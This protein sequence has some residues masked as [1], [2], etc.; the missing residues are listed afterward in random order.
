[1]ADVDMRVEGR[2]E[3]DDWTIWHPVNSGVLCASATVV[4]TALSISILFVS[5]FHCFQSIHIP[6]L[7]I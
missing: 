2:M 5:F 4:K 7:I 1:M 3:S 6:V